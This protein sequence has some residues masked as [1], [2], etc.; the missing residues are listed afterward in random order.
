MAFEASVGPYVIYGNLN[1]VQNTEPDMGPSATMMGD[2]VLDPRFVGTI[3][4]AS[5]TGQN[6]IYAHSNH[7]YFCLVDAVPV[8]ASN[9]KIV[10][11]Q[12]S[13]VVP[14]GGTLALTT[15]ASSSAGYALNIP[16]VPQG[17]ALNS[18]NVVNCIALDFGFTTATTTA[19]S[20][21]ITIPAGAGRFFQVGQKIIISGAGSA[22]TPQIMTVATV[23]TTPNGTTFTTVENAVAA[24][25]S[26]ACGNAYPGVG[27]AAWPWRPQGVMALA[28]PYQG[29][30][31]VLNVTSSGAGGTG[32]TVLIR[33]YDIWGFPMAER[34]AV[35][36]SASTTAGLK[37]FKYISS[38]T[39]EKSG[40]GTFGANVSVGTTDLIGFNVRSDFWE[41]LNIFYNG[42][43]VS[44]S[45]GYTAAVATSPA[46]ATTGDV[47]GTYALQSASDGVKRLAIFMTLP[48]YEILNSTNL[49]YT[50]M[51]GVTQFT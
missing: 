5:S 20:N 45:T 13:P 40:G 2:A 21:T 19:G 39:L 48:Q 46:T 38:V 33:G 42:V 15:V 25:A 26:G 9:T 23:P 11:A 22:T 14:A 44:T 30:A 31:R 29:L 36:N 35:A 34:I 4:A 28:D 16:V 17:S 51:F 3:G 37:A 7:A 1:P 12:A 49:N 27:L 18:S 10:N 41:Y 47:R 50:S 24:V 6:K 8:T 32:Y 43:F